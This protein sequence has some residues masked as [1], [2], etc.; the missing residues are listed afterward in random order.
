MRA[1]VQKQN[2]T[3]KLKKKK[4]KAFRK[5]QIDNIRDKILI[6]L[7]SKAKLHWKSILLQ[8]QKSTPALLCVALWRNN[9]LLVLHSRGLCE[10][11]EQACMLYYKCIQIKLFYIFK[12][13]FA[14]FCVLYMLHIHVDTHNFNTYL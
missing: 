13:C 11:R 2:K 5:K 14:Y 8:D 12:Y 7:R 1:E 10:R 4:A 9:C 3:K 6:Q